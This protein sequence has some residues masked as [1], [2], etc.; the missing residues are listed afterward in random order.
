M[1]YLIYLFILMFVMRFVST[2]FYIHPL[3]GL[4]SMTGFY[5]MMYRR[6]R[7]LYT[8]NFSNI[9]NQNRNYQNRNYYERSNNSTYENTSYSNVNRGEVF[10]AEYTESEVKTY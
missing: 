5:Y 10:E 8:R 4:L 1:G 3:L 2:L 7:V 9:N 6:P